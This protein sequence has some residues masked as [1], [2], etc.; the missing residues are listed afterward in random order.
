MNADEQHKRRV[1][2]EDVRKDMKQL[3]K[4]LGT[5][6]ESTLDEIRIIT[7]RMT[8]LV[9]DYQATTKQHFE[10]IHTRISNLTDDVAKD[11]LD[12][13]CRILR[14]TRLT[15]WGRLKWL[16]TGHVETKTVTGQASAVD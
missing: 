14:L 13:E 6:C 15:L 9:K 12:L 10:D 2:I 8:D 1:A 7:G 16:V 4:D 11:V 3:E 5:I